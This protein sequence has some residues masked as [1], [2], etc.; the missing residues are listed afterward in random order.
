MELTH[1]L[2]YSSKEKVKKPVRKLTPEKQIWPTATSQQQILRN[3]FKIACQRRNLPFLYY[4]W[5]LTISDLRTACWILSSV[6]LT[7]TDRCIWFTNP[8]VRNIIECYSDHWWTIK[9]LHCIYWYISS[10][11]TGTL[12]VCTITLPLGKKRKKKKESKLSVS[13][14]FGAL[15]V[16]QEKGDRNNKRAY[17]RRDT[18]TCCM[19]EWRMMGIF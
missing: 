13:K 6:N 11:W 4:T 19:Q 7:S 12:F 8:K 18:P 3:I 10:C 15:S 5:F 17:G 9:R 16:W 14:A 2:L 1:S